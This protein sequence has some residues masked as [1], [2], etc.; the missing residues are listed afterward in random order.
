MSE[1]IAKNYKILTPPPRLDPF[2]IVL[3]LVYKKIED[4]NVTQNPFFLGSDMPQYFRIYPH[5]VFRHQNTCLSEK[6]TI[7][8]VAPEEPPFNTNQYK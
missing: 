3:Q 7:E 6:E 8:T 2:Y 5:F 1:K 4:I